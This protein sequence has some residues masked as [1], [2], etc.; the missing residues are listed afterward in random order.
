[1]PRWLKPHPVLDRTRVRADAAAAEPT[2]RS[3]L[4]LAPQQRHVRS[5]YSPTDLTLGLFPDWFGPPQPDWPTN[6]ARRLSAVGLHDYDELSDEVLEFLAAG[7]PPI[8]FSPGSANREATAFFA[9]AVD[10]CERLG[11][12][13]ILLTKYDEQLPA[14]CPK[15]YA[16][17]ALCR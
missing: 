4:G 7:T 9:A 12:R 1:M 15:R 10:A 6:A 8:A 13:G 3:E 2:L 14:K 16:T 17:S 5:G 11:R